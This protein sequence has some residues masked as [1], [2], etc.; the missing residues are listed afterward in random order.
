MDYPYDLGRFSRK[1]TT[2]NLEA[3]MWFDRGLNWIYGFN[4][5]EAIACFQRAYGA[6][7]TCAMAYWGHAYAA[8]PNYNMPWV[9]YDSK[10]LEEALNEAY[11]AT[12][13][14][15]VHI[16]HVTPVEKALIN[17]LIHRYPQRKP[18]DDMAPWDRDF[19]DAMRAVHGRFPDD[20]EVATCFVDA[21]MNLTPWKM[22]DLPE[23]K[24]ASGA[25][26]VEARQVLERQM[27]LPGGMSHPGILHLYVHLMEMSPH[28]ELALKAADVLRTLVPDAGHLVHMPSHIDV[29][30][31][32]YENVVRW[33]EKAIEA[34][35]IYYE[36]E[37]AF[38]I[39]TGYRQHN[40]HFVIYGALFLG[41]FE[42]AMRA[43][44]GMDDTTPEAL[45]KVQSPPMADFLESYLS[46][47]PHV[48]IRFG[49][50]EEVLRL[51][52]PDDIETRCT[53]VAMIEYAKALALS[54]LGRISEAETQYEVFA[55]AKA[56]VPDSRLLHNVRVVDL[57][58]L[59]TAMLDGELAY[60]KGDYAHAF[61]RLRDAVALDDALP[62]DEPWGW[63]QPTRHALGALLFEQGHHRD[64]EEVF[65]QDLGLS[66]GLPRACQHP[67]NI[68]ALRGL[69][70]CL[71]AQGKTAE[72][73]HIKLRLDLAEARSDR[74]VKAACGCAQAA[75][76]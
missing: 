51:T 9:L 70:D 45:L 26:T 73:A 17:T 37:G 69:Y 53:K 6:D 35:L 27:A 31:G 42:P 60:R 20:P 41:Q 16:A 23:G 65:R 36:A 32:Q 12:R 8:G 7:P 13:K 14:A 25:A 11:T 49:K 10:G 74:P 66:P 38:N 39:Y 33:N 48:L 76:S 56:R 57:L 62:Y 18:V 63:M 46:M 61:K 75:M 50:W 4:H 72:T 19:A 30:C 44:R 28:P 21:L 43:V 59:A 24:I 64:A 34:D 71:V 40:Y 52:L 2:D 29:L 5:K 67:D 47:E 1:V 15:L 3:Q 54:A 58:D 55:R 22:W 68:W